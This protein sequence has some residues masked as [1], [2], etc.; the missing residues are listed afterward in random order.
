M[1]VIIPVASLGRYFSFWAGFPKSRM[2]LKPID[3]WAPRVMPMPRS[4]PPTIS[5]NRAY[6]EMDGYYHIR[7]VA[8]SCLHSCLTQSAT[9]QYLLMCVCF[10]VNIHKPNQAD[11]PVCLRGRGHP[12]QLAPA[13]R[14]RPSPSGPPWCDPPPSPRRRSWQDRSPPVHGKQKHERWGGI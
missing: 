2:P 10:R 5:T 9:R 3:W 4:W 8:P 7:L 12:G 13:G 6:C 14:R 1:L 11:V